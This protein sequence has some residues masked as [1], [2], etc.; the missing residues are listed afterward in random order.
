MTRVFL[1]AGSVKDVSD[2]AESIIKTHNSCD[3]RFGCVDYQFCLRVYS[4]T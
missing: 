4:Q 1:N 3:G 2:E